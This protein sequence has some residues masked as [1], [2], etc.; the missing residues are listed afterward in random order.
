MIKP[1]RYEHHKGGI[2]VVICCALDDTTK[3]I[4]VVYYNETHGSYYTRS[5]T[6]FTQDLGDDKVPRFKL[7]S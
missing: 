2:Y 6:E 7:I 1:G 3:D 4:V 5:L